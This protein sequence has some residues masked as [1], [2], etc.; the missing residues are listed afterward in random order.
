MKESTPCTK[1][2][3]IHSPSG[4]C[5]GCGRTLDEIQLWPSLSEPERLGIMA[6]LP[7]R[8]A[9]SRSERVAAAGRTNRRRTSPPC[10]AE[11]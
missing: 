11:G 9:R 6:G 3:L 7:A 2:C 5:Q 10:A 1:I 8:L 4:L